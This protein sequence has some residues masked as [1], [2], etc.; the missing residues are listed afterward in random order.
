MIKILI[1]VL[2]K[3]DQWMGSLTRAKVFEMEEKNKIKNKKN[4][5]KYNFFGKTRQVHE[6]T[7]LK[8]NPNY[9]YYD[10]YYYLIL[11]NRKQKIE[12]V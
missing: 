4:K 9:D 3:F 2:I 11:Q 7:F 12:L 6:I 8:R 1:R 5:K 10:Y